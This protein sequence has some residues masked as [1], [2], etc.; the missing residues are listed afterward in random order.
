MHDIKLL[1]TDESVQQT[2]N[3]RTQVSTSTLLYRTNS[4]AMS[5]FRE[6]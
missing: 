6:P 4:E 3:T 1:L 5:G 2:G